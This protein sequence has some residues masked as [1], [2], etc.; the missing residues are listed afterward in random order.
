MMNRNLQGMLEAET[1]NI[2]D[3]EIPVA[4]IARFKKGTTVILEAIANEELWI[5]ACNS[6]LPVRVDDINILD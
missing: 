5:W 2:R 1:S 6:D 3:G 4:W